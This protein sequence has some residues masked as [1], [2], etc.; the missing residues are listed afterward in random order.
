M[1][2]FVDSA[3]STAYSRAEELLQYYG[4]YGCDLLRTL[5]ILVGQVSATTY[6][7]ASSLLQRYLNEIWTRAKLVGPEAL[8][9]SAERSLLILEQTNVVTDHNLLHNVAACLLIAIK[10]V[11][12]RARLRSIVLCVD[13]V[14]RRWRHIPVF[15]TPPQ[16]ELDRLKCAI[17]VAEE[18]ILSALSFRTFVD[19]PHKYALIFIKL[20]T[21][22]SPNQGDADTTEWQP[23]DMRWAEDA[24][25]ICNDSVRTS[26]VVM[27]P[28]AVVGAV[29]V[30]LTAPVQQVALTRFTE[31]W[32][33]AVGVDYK[34]FLCCR[35][36][37][38]SMYQKIQPGNALIQ[39]FQRPAT[40]GAFAAP[41]PRAT[42]PPPSAAIPLVS[43]PGAQQGGI[44]DLLVPAGSA[45]K[46]ALHIPS[47][48]PAATVVAAPP[49]PG[50]VSP[51][52]VPAPT[53]FAAAG[54][55]LPSA[56]VLPIPEFEVLETYREKKGKKK[57][58]KEKEGKKE[59]EKPV[60]QVPQPQPQ[61][62]IS[63]V[64]APLAEPANVKL[65]E[66]VAAATVL[67][68]LLASDVPSASRTDT[69][70]TRHRKRSRS[71]DSRD[72]DG[73]RRRSRSK[74]HVK[75]RSRSRNHSRNHSRPRNAS[76]RRSRSRD[77]SDR[78]D[79]RRNS[80]DRS[81]DYRRRSP[82]RSRR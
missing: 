52:V 38:N 43:G 39:A 2:A 27:M 80:R 77:R 71:E 10:V 34:A 79:Q 67:Q 57:S 6:F 61:A 9:P 75:P 25:A 42:S 37:I 58:R 24:I 28:A 31:Q 63:V 50:G 76:R 64:P 72:R 44:V 29:A 41:A 82:P 15:A 8:P 74:D 7:H 30:F 19:Y 33:D 45:G 40:V 59:D 1:D 22:V 35:D 68:P 56:Q 20:M 70:E 46:S 55:F 14:N 60:E 51:R 32:C 3:N 36:A 53:T 81:R 18:K 73:R 21:S 26:H 48:P 78:R 49:Q 17:V 62:P 13:R 11:D 16:D 65:P 47:P 66:E 54:S 12:S 23:E 5:S 69:S 4:A